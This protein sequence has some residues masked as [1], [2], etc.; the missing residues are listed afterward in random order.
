MLC[1]RGYELQG[2]FRVREPLIMQFTIVGIVFL[3]AAICSAIFWQRALLVVL[4]V[5]SPFVYTVAV[6]TALGSVPVFEMVAAVT[7]VVAFINLS[8][9]AR[10]ASIGPF[11]VLGAFVAWAAVGAAV[12]PV[13]FAG[14]PVLT[15]RAGIDVGVVA[16]S[17]LTSGLPQLAQVIYLVVSAGAALFV[18]QRKE[19]AVPALSIAFFVGAAVNALYFMI[20]SATPVLDELLRNSVNAGYNINEKRFFGAFG[21]PS[22][23]S[24]FSVTALV[25]AFY[26][27]PLARA[28]ERVIQA[29][30]LVLAVVESVVS[31]SGTA[32]LSIIALGGCW[33]IYYGAGFMFRRRRLPPLLGIVVLL[34]VFVF[35]TPNR[36]S[37]PIYDTIFYKTDTSS[38]TNRTASDLFSLHLVGDTFG[39]GVGLGT[40]RPSSFV[41]FVL[42]TTGVIGFG[43]LVVLV[44]F[45]LRRAWPVLETRSAAAALVALI[46][47]KAVA[48]PD[49]STPLFWVAIGVCLQSAYFAQKAQVDPAGAASVSQDLA[50][51]QGSSFIP[52][53][54]IGIREISDLC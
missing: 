25:F 22:V 39:L 41:T 6:N 14:L 35:A 45:C 1:R 19:S 16:P 10:V 29:I 5:A 37:A 17:P 43:L 26:R 53:Q 30:T 4:A 36:L 28:A 34:V 11:A 7:T 54:N 50:L 3:L 15:P 47:T 52:T 46:V 48:V 31:V 42:S 44:V 49:L 2:L 13:L 27:I 33:L 23:A 32:A 21:E 8:R 20:P 18:A 40:N 12:M 9:G 24:M 51:A 38:F